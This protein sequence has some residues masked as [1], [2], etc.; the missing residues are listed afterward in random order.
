VKVLITGNCGYIGSHLSKILQ[1]RG[2]PFTGCDW[3]HGGFDG[4]YRFLPEDD[5]DVVIHLAASVSV[6]GSFSQPLEYFHNNAFGLRDFL[7][8]S[9]PKRIIF[10][11]TGGAMYGDKVL[12]REEDARYDLC[13]SPYAQS[14]F[15]AEEIVRRE[16]NHCI[17]RLANV[18]GGDTSIRGE[19]A[20]HAHF[21]QDD[22]IVI[23]GGKQTRD[24][25]HIDK[26]CGAIIKALEDPTITGTFNIGSGVETSIIDIANEYSHQ[27]N[28][29]VEIKPERAGEVQHISLDITKAKEAG[30]L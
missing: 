7:F 29:P 1:E 28:V 25:I 2:I 15:I 3:K 24:F 13:L 10:I 26:V 4:D 17:L 30:L 5:Y 11:S 19:A 27:R 22:P 23:Y 14:K 18:Y 20:V 8:D 9:E 21:A 6:T 16:N 12:A